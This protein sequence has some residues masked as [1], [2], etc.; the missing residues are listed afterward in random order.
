[1]GGTEVPSSEHAAGG[2][3]SVA[4]VDTAVEVADGEGLR[5]PMTVASPGLPGGGHGDHGDHGGS[6]G[7]DVFS[8]VGYAFDAPSDE[9]TVHVDRYG[10]AVVSTYGFEDYPALAKVVSHGIGLS[11]LV[12]LALD[13]GGAPATGTG[14][15]V[16]LG[17]TGRGLPAGSG[18]EHTGRWPT[19]STSRGA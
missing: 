9:R 11:L 3:A 4:N 16:R 17:L 7:R 14:P 1:M 13:A 15:D 8:V 6:G 19:Q 5:H 2:G 12:V 18:A 10:G